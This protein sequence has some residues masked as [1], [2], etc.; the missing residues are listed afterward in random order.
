MYDKL[1]ILLNL[2]AS[3]CNH[4]MFQSLNDLVGLNE[5]EIERVVY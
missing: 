2:G 1:K 4:A 3:T 5:Q